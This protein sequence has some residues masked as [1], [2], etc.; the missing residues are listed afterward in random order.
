ML[1]LKLELEEGEVEVEVGELR[2]PNLFGGDH[3]PF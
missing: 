2:L 3:M 1:E